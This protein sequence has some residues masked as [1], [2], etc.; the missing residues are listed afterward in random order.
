MSSNQ[1]IKSV[2][3]ASVTK[4]GKQVILA[5]ATQTQKWRRL[6]GVWVQKISLGKSYYSPRR[7]C[8]SRLT[9]G[10]L[11]HLGRAKTDHSPGTT[12]IQVLLTQETTIQDVATMK[13][14][15]LSRGNISPPSS[16]SNPRHRGGKGQFYNYEI[17]CK[18]TL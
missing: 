11:F 10:A 18:E 17:I 7:Y 13:R 12:S 9:V 14:A 3:V 15:T 8:Q 16:E 5:V 4:G 6:P 1:I 2:N